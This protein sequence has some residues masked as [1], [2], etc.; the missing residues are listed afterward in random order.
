[1]SVAAGRFEIT[2]L[3]DA[4]GTFATVGQMFPVESSEPLTLPFH[5]YLVRGP[6]LVALV[7]T[8]LGPLPRDF[9][10]ETEGR[11][12]ELLR[13]AGV[14]PDDVQLVVLTHLHV[15]H[16]GWTPLF[17]RARVVAARPDLDWFRA[18]RG[19]QAYFKRSVEAVQIE[20]LDGETELAPGLRAVPAY[21]HTPGHLRAV[22]DG[23]A[24]H[25]CAD[26]AVHELQL[27]DPGVPYA[28]EVDKE[29]AAA[30][31]RELLPAFAAAGV[32]VALAHLPSGIGL[33]RRE[34]DG[35]GWQPL[36]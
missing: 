17:E 22:L 27:H 11:L 21:G 28:L 32:P 2:P 20:L 26:L 8:G 18:E 6:E 36:G 34:A 23:G 16:V 31:R 10:P 3:L 7:D 25:L 5:A 19:E 13:T 24:A 29:R 33:V 14:Q 35:F 30:L 1:V 15:D 4:A 12:P 9:L